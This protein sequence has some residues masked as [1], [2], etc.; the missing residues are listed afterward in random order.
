MFLQQFDAGPPTYGQWYMTSGFGTMHET[1]CINIDFWLNH[2]RCYNYA[3][4]P[5]INIHTL[6]LC[7]LYMTSSSG[8]SE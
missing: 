1:A 2:I 6:L 7:P 5:E 8:T 4:E 3:V